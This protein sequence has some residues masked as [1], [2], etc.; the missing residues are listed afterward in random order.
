MYKRF[1]FVDWM[2]LN[3]HVNAIKH[4]IDFFLDG[5]RSSDITWMHG[6]T[7]RESLAEMTKKPVRVRPWF[8]PG[9][10]GGTWIKDNIQGLEKDVLN[11]AWSF[12]L[13]SPENG[14]ILESSGLMLEVS[15]DSLMYLCAQ[16]ILGA[17]YT[18][19]GYYFPIR[20][21]FL[22]T[23]DGGNLSVQCHPRIEYMKKHFGEA[24]TQEETYYILDR[25]ENAIVYLG[26]QEDVT[27]DEFKQALENSQLQK[28]PINVSKYVQTFEANK[29]DLFLIP[30]GT[31]HASGTGNLVLEI[32]STP[33]IYT[34]K[35][36]DWLRVDLDGKP[37]PLN[38]ERGIENLDM[39]R[40]GSKVKEELISK[41]ALIEKTPQ[42]SLHHLPTHREHLYDV[43]RYEIVDSVVVKNDNK[44]HVMSLVEGETVEIIID[45]KSFHYSYAE[46]FIIPSAVESYT[47]RNCTSSTIMV[48]KAFIK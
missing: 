27:L 35:M 16:N 2:I 18:K 43:H 13:I 4:N 48:I 17:D 32:S 46:T 12:E 31:I 33:Y 36:Y 1:Y 19:Y 22:D 39:G 7:W 24:I 45:G 40:S 28:K 3:R 30:P 9:A 37:R 14:V 41:P 11:Y 15:F 25:Q 44:A 23:F 20:F 38:I 34:F 42:Y 29:H 10:W 8:E 5:Q 47:I 6:N 26:F 21:D